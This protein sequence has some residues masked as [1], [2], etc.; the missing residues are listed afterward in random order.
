[1]VNFFNNYKC[2]KKII[3]SK[4]YDINF[5]LPDSLCKS[6]KLYGKKI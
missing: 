6:W 2:V 5:Q 1:M 3:N 4:D